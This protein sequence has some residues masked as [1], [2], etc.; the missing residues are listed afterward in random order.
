MMFDQTKTNK[1]M[2]TTNSEKNSQMQMLVGH[3]TVQL[4]EKEEELIALK[5]VNRQL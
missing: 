3:L 5:S 2:F 1:S 4:T